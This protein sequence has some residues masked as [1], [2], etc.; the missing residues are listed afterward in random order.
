MDVEIEKDAENKTENR[1]EN[2]AENEADQQGAEKEEEWLGQWTDDMD[3]SLLLSI[4]SSSGDFTAAAEALRDD[5]LRRHTRRGGIQGQE[6]STDRSLSPSPSPLDCLA[7]LIALPIARTTH[8]THTN[9][10]P[11]SGHPS[12]PPSG[13]LSGVPSGPP[14]LSRAALLNV[15]LSSDIARKGAHALG[16]EDA[17]RVVAATIK[18]HMEVNYLTFFVD[19][20]SILYYFHSS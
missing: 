1:A 13:V 6:N 10:I 12:G 18:A 5:A 8:T 19:A 15:T 17:R 14:G 20:L 11:P 16:C 3:N 9:S 7:R 2:K 4:M